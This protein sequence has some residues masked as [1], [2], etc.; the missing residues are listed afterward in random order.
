MIRCHQCQLPIAS[1][2]EE[3]AL[4][5]LKYI[6]RKK[7]EHLSRLRCSCPF[8]YDNSFTSRPHAPDLQWYDK[9]S[10]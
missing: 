3:S 10:I 9:F 7:W 2:I 4:R 5:K 1:A 6:D 8:R